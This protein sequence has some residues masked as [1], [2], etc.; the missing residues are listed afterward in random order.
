MWR[1]KNKYFP[2]PYICIKRK[3]KK[4]AEKLKLGTINK[5]PNEVIDRTLTSVEV[6]PTQ[7]EQVITAPEGYNG[8]NEV[9]VKGA[10]LQQKI[11]TPSKE[12]QVIKADDGYYGLSDVIVSPPVIDGEGLLEAIN[13]KISNAETSINQ[14]IANAE[15]NINA[16]IDETETNINDSLQ[17]V[18]DYANGEI[19]RMIDERLAVDL[20][21][22]Y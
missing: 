2:N 4:M 9:K 5:L 21:A 1:L 6:E 11:V 14:N 12:T 20:E 19:D 18:I 16:N 17:V 22:D 7:E 3:E 15:T 10:R 13:N 8:F